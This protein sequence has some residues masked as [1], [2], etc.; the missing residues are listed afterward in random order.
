MKRVWNVLGKLLRKESNVLTMVGDFET[1]TDINDVR[2]WASCL[3]NVEDF[4]IEQLGNDIESFIDFIANKNSVVYFHNLKFDGEFIIHY[5]LTHGFKLSDSKEDNTFNTLITDMGQFYSLTIYF[6]KMR[7]K[8][9]KCTIYDSLKKL[10]FKV[11]VIAEAFKLEESKLVI[12]YKET[13][14]LG[15]IL[16][17]E[18]K[19]Y[20]IADCMIVAKA[21]HQQFEQGLTKMT[22]GADA[23]SSFKQSIGV[24]NFE[25]W[26]PI[27]PLN[28]DDDVRRAYK[29]GWTYLNPLYK[30]VRTKGLVLD[31]NSLYPWAM[32]E[33][34]LPY[35][36]PIAYDG[37][38]KEDKVY[39]LYIQ[40]FRCSFKVKKGFV[41]TVQLKGNHSYIQTEYLSTS[42][43]AIE[44]LTMTNVDYDLFRKHY[45]ILNMEFIQGYKFKSCQGIF[46]AYIDKWMLVKANSTGGTR[47]G[48]KLMLNNLYGKFATN[49]K[50]AKKYPYLDKDSIV[51][52]YNDG[53]MLIDGHVVEDP[54]Y[55]ETF[56]NPVFTP[57]GCFITA[58]S[59]VKTITTAQDN[60]ERFMYSDTDSEHLEGWKLPSN[61]EIH[62]TNLGAFKLEGKFE[63]CLFL[64][65]KTYME[66]INGI[67]HVTCAGMPDKVKEQVTYD[68]FTEGATYT[69]KLTPKR[70]KG[71]IVL[72][73]T[74]FKIKKG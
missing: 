49:P 6:K 51:R 66:T 64:R 20:V 53:Q 12:D 7:K 15:H 2:V 50:G 27:L 4:V 18:E 16:T 68:N 55:I 63:D 71:G 44:E 56:R 67:T 31:V 54:D 36:Y 10:P 25:R 43:G 74:T 46:N 34:P 38:Y 13:R 22:I 69:G 70:Y 57:M 9:L 5:L 32:H 72:Q 33:C 41:P 28:I 21:L 17:H 29:G 42:H 24:K 37:G 14:P 23:L 3:V 52:Y 39:P 45:V 61:V 65:P 47:Q 26:F 40:R 8:Y 59:R 19:E 60:I 48:A 58:H 35:G 62:D 1:T 30:G 11:S 73:D